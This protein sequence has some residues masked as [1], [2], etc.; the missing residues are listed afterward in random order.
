[1][2]IIGDQHHFVSAKTSVPSRDIASKTNFRH[3]PANTRD[4]MNLRMGL[5]VG[6][7]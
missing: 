6:R 1:M 2:K 5:S 7:R 4:R 3:V